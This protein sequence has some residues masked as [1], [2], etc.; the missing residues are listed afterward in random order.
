MRIPAGDSGLD[1]IKTYLDN[2]SEMLPE[3]VEIELE[4]ETSRD[5][6]F[7]FDFIESDHPRDLA[8]KFSAV[9]GAAGKIPVNEKPLS[10]FLQN[11]N[12]LNALFQSLGAEEYSASG[13]STGIRG[14]YRDEIGKRA[15][16][17]FVWKD[18]KQT[19]KKLSGTSVILHEG[20]FSSQSPDQ[21]S[22]KKIIDLV[23]NYG[24]GEAI[25]LI[26][27][28]LDTDADYNDVGEAIVKNPKILT[29]IIND[30]HYKHDQNSDAST[31]F[32]FTARTYD[33]NGWL[34]ISRSHISKACVN[35]YYGREIPGGDSLELIPDKVYYL[36][37]SPD[38][39]A[40]A[41]DTFKGIPILSKHIPLKDFATMEEAEKKKYIVGAV[42]S[43]VEF[44]SPYL[45][46]DTS[47]WDAAAIAGIE[48]E[49]QREHSCSYRYVP[50]MT[51]GTYEGQKF[52][53]IMTQIQANHLCM[54][55]AGRAGNDVL[56]AD[57]QL[58]GSMKVTRLGKA[59][60]VALQ[61]A[62]PKVK[63]AEDSEITKLFA[64]AT[65]STLDKPAAIKLV[66]AMDAEMP[67]KEKEVKAVMDALVDADDPEPKKEEKD[68]KDKKAKDKRAMDANSGHPEGC[69]CADCKSARDEEPEEEEKEK[70]KKA[71]DKKAMDQLASDL[72]AEFREASEAKADVRP[73]VGDVIAM[74]SAAEI[75]GFALDQMKV[76]HKGVEGV[77]ALRALFKVAREQAAKPAAPVIAMDAAAVETQ[78]PGF[79]RVS[80]L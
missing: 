12:E 28:D 8:G 32:D 63:F 77:P 74:D 58:G 23:K 73:V 50:I 48:T 3:L 57:S 53:G 27:G 13:N 40:K 20:D 64:G 9:K 75:Y 7:S 22:I 49:V 80:R 35:P 10:H 69:M 29:Y 65:K 72:R 11:P 16:S 31:A 26:Q 14:A 71:D 38:E 21:K 37:R 1:V 2:R 30:L 66:L 70:K 52:D 76:D 61:T 79:N 56:A 34:H 5:A 18:Q 25:A 17:S 42:G 62:F 78:F 45:D 33:A 67:A 55:E 59:L 15:R 47:I 51:T 46:A 54:V 60:M 44:L 68:A 19:S 39:L 6:V 4:A 36:L 43:N 41:A 24:T